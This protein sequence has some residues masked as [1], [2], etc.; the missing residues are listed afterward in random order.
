[1]RLGTRE[2]ARFCHIV[3][4]SSL[5]ESVAVGPPQP[6]YLN[7]AV[8]VQSRLEPADLMKALLLTERG[9]GRIRRGRWGARTLDLDIL[10][11][12]AR[13]V[14]SIELEVPHPRLCER[15][16]AILPLLDVAPDAADP[17]TGEPYSLVL[18]HL[19]VAGVRRIGDS[20]W[21]D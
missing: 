13:R 11:I 14:Q 19:D 15:A 20:D 18:S 12:R 9:L 4:I 6:D 17:V 10:W 8:R 7:A 21:A 5:Y 1:M 16:F 2:L 3:G